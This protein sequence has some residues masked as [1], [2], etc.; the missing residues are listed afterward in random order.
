MYRATFDGVP[1]MVLEFSSDDVTQ[2]DT[3]KRL[4]T[5]QPAS[6]YRG[7]LAGATCGQGVSWDIFVTTGDALRR[8]AEAGWAAEVAGT[9]QVVSA[10]RPRRTKLRQP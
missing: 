2:V 9:R 4:R 6:G 3:A 8:G 10:D 5:A 1:D 7:K